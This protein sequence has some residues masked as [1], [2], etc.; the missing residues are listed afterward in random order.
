MESKVAELH[1]TLKVP[2]QVSV[3]VIVVILVVVGLSG[4]TL[5]AL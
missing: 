4:W 3:Q 2:A 1:F 5:E